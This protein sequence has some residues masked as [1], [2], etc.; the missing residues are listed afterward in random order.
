MVAELYQKFLN[1][2]LN[3]R[4]KVDEIITKDH[5]LGTADADFIEEL[6]AMDDT[7]LE[8]LDEESQEILDEIYGVIERNT[9]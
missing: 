5:L 4:A 6:D 3:N 9:P 1:A 2:D 8:A 7:Q